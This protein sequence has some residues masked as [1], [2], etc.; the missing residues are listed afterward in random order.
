MPVHSVSAASL[1]TYTHSHQFI[2]PPSVCLRTQMSNFA[3]YT[4]FGHCISPLT[5]GKNFKFKQMMQRLL[6]RSKQPSAFTCSC[7]DS[8]YT[9]AQGAGRGNSAAHF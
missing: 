8:E 4:H 6:C 2:T 7:Q 1:S 3:N 9:E 5:L